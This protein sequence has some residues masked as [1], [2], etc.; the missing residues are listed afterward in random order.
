MKKR[1]CNAPGTNGQDLDNIITPD[2]RKKLQHKFCAEGSKEKPEWVKMTEK[3]QM[4]H[5]HKY[6]E[7][8][9]D[10]HDKQVL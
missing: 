4:Q 9:S 3:N 5:H 7:E 8:F 1:I 10:I 2:G 6:F